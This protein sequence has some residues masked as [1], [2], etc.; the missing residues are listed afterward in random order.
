MLDASVPIMRSAWIMPRAM[1]IGRWVARMLCDINVPRDE[2]IKYT[3]AAS[4][5]E[6]HGHP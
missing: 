2:I 6:G 5:C 3:T 4:S 1:A